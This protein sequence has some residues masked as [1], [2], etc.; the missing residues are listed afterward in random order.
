MMLAEE[1]TTM[2]DVVMKLQSF[3]MDVNK[4]LFNE[5]IQIM[6]DVGGI[7]SEDIENIQVE[8]EDGD[9]IQQERI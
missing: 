2:K 7:K 9:I 1:I 8:M 5:R 6:S 4:T 3:T